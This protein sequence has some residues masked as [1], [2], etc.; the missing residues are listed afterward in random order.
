MMCHLEHP[1]ER[2]NV[3]EGKAEETWLD[4][5]SKSDSEEGAC[6]H[7]DEA[8]DVEPEP[9]PAVGY[10]PPPPARRV[11]LETAHKVGMH[12]ALPAVCTDGKQPGECGVE[13]RVHRRF[14]GTIEPLELLHGALSVLSEPNHDGEAKRDESGQP[15]NDAAGQRDRSDNPTTHPTGAV[16]RTHR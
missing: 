16:G 4:V 9:E 12:G 7:E 8:E 10:E 3:N 1:G 13:G 15:R 14:G 6:R 5:V 11:L 2:E